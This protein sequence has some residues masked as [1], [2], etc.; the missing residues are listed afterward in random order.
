ML[1]LKWTFVP[2]LL[3]LLALLVQTQAEIREL[4]SDE[5]EGPNVCKKR[6]K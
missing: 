3:L 1:R 5:P 2:L 4:H 6:E